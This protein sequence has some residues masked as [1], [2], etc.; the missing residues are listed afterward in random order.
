[1]S[2]LRGTAVSPGIAVG[3]ALVVERD[4]VPVFRLNLAPEK[5]PAEIG[6]LEAALE[7]SRE[8]LRAIKER[9]SRE[10][11][12][13]HAYIFDAHL[14]MLDDPLLRA[15]AVEIVQQQLVNA[16]WALRTVSEELHGL[17]DEFSDEYLRER[18]S[19]LDDVIGRVQL[20]LRGAPGAPS[21][22]RLPGPFVLVASDLSPS[23]AAELDWDRVL[24]VATDMGSSTYHTAIIARSLR[25]P[26]V[27]G[28]K[29]ATRQTPAGSLV[30]VDGTRGEVV[31]EPSASILDGFRRDQETYR[32]EDERLC[33]TRELPSRTQDGVDVR[34][35][36][37]V[38]FPEEAATAQLYGAEGIGLFR[39]EYL[40]GRDPRWPSEDQQLDVYRRLIEQMHPHAVTVRTWDVGREALGT[41][42]PSGPNPAMGERALRLLR[43][44]PDPFRVQLRALLR[45]GEHGP[46]RI[47]FPFVAGVGDLRLALSLLDEAREELRRENVAFREDVPVGVNLEVPSAAVVV[48]LLVTEVDFFS[49]GTNDLIQ[50]LLAVDR[51][52]PRVS[53]LYEPLH[54]A[55]LRTLARIAA[56][57]RE[58][59]R[60]LSLCGEMA[61]QPVE[62]VLLVGLGYRELSM[63]PSA[64]PR[65]KAAVR[66]VREDE[67]RRL[68]ERCLSLGTREETVR[69]VREELPEAAGPAGPVQ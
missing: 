5:I 20:N 51:T 57:A 1:M 41:V 10:V 67:A 7:V 66:A 61:G 50:Y 21:L 48:D 9:L 32:R 55:V 35:V 52:D 18:S 23:E 47:M 19:D 64:I 31:V 11:G 68:A 49:V 44:S 56:V 39:S 8:Q 22:E 38:E 58:H 29:D 17:F 6:R 43:R 12:A 36:A 25:I 15:R 34:L 69:F 42:G 65:V 62:A 30:V 16:E 40:L 45:A 33:S 13:P 37:N 24:A 46:I 4:A 28:L 26:A 2:T 54:P 27:V 63:A 53:A 3:R 60:P 14:L 59:D